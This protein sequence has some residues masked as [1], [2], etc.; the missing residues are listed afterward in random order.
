MQLSSQQE[1][2]LRDVRDWFNNSD[3]QVFHLFGYA[4]TGKTTIAKRLVEG[5]EN[6]IFGAFTGKA[7]YVLQRSGCPGAAT[8]HSLIYNPKD[9][10]KAHLQ[11]LVEDLEY[12]LTQWRQSA[13]EGDP[14]PSKIRDLREEIAEEQRNLRRPM[15]TLKLESPLRDAD[16]LV[17]DECS[18]VDRVMGEDLLSFGVKTLVMGDPAQ[19]PPVGSA[20]FFNPRTPDA[21]LEQIHRQ[22][23]GNPIIDLAT[24]VRNG[25]RLRRGQYGESSVISRDELTPE[26]AMGADQIIV[27]TNKLRRA[28]NNHVRR[29][30]G[31]EGPFPVVGDRLVCLKNNHEKGI[32][33]GALYE[34]EQILADPSPDEDTI[35]MIVKDEEGSYE[36]DAHVNPFMGDDVPP[37]A[38]KDTDSFDYG[39]AIT[40]HKSQGSQFPKVLVYDESRVFRKDARKWLYTAITRAQEKVTVVS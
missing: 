32:L 31:R 17:I 12:A 15:F 21:M 29:K 28:V 8:I 14:E 13:S 22:A 38:H 10:S 27:G 39:Y 11:G 9:K 34:V 33:N 4:G 7:A 37:W 20:G 19:L 16:L 30:L 2:A 23:E 40:C 5:I 36:I 26:I 3:E 1:R 35:P 25:E 6:V 18:M 24:T